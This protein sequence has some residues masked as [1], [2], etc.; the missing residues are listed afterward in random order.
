MEE[1]ILCSFDM[2]RILYDAG[3]MPLHAASLGGHTGQF[4]FERLFFFY[5]FWTQLSLSP[6]YYDMKEYR[7]MYSF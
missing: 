6:N 7:T 1:S 5:F 2:I 3:I 4:S